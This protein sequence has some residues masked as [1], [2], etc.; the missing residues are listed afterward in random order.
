MH[1]KGT[2]DG[3]YFSVLPSG[4]VEQRS[5]CVLRLCHPPFILS[6]IYRSPWTPLVVE[7]R[8][9]SLS[10]PLIS[11]SFHPFVEPRLTVPLAPWTCLRGRP[12][13]TGQSLT[14]ENAIFLSISAAGKGGGVAEIR[15]IQWNLRGS[16]VR[17]N[18]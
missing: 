18:D 14:P 7:Q 5:A 3:D 6:L 13:G 15:D 11:P 17:A 10:L 12:W 4:S 9:E 2:L 1:F 8:S 16:T